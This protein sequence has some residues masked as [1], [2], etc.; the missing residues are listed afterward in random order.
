LPVMRWLWGY[1]PVRTVAL[2]GQHRLWVTYAFVN[3][4]PCAPTRSLRVGMVLH[5]LSGMSS[6]MTKVM[7]GLVEAVRARAPLA[8]KGV[9]M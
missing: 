6:V 7:L 4:A 9:T 1:L 2:E 3:L 5:N 8:P